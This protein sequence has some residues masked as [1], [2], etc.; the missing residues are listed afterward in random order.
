MKFIAHRGLVD[1]PDNKL[2]NLPEQILNSLQAG[3]DCEIDVR[4]VNNKWLLGHDAPDFEVP[5]EFLEQPGLWIH[6]KNLLALEHLAKT[7][8]EYFWHQSDDFV[9]TS[10][11]YIW[12][13]PG[14][15]LTQRSIMVMPEHVDK[16]LDTTHNLNCYAICSDYVEKIKSFY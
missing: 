6:A 11:N 5:F 14:K 7:K 12:T 2:E 1:G 10:N 4:L 16:S 15:S 13:F 8:L 9:L 3:Y